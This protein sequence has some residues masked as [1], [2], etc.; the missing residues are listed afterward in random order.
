MLAFEHD[1]A[2]LTHICVTAAHGYDAFPLTLGPP[3]T[4]LYIF[5]G[6]VVALAV[7]P[8]Y[9]PGATASRAQGNFYTVP[10]E[11]LI[12]PPSPNS[13]NRQSVFNVSL[14]GYSLPRSINS[15]LSGC[16]LLS[17]LPPSW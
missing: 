9:T 2:A 14:R 7:Q 16:G 12:S 11:N 13:A 15:R 17:S 3:G 10:G 1:K 5:L 4:G 8:A 6:W